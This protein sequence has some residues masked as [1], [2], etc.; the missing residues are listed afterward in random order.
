VYRL[1]RASDRGNGRG[2]EH[3]HDGKD[4]TAL[5]PGEHVNHSLPLGQPEKYRSMAATCVNLSCAIMRVQ[6]LLVRVGRH[7]FGVKFGTPRNSRLCPIP[8]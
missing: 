2:E 4:G 3:E 7:T 8:E 1:G 6:R 5:D